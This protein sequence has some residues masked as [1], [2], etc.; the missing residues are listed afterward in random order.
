MHTDGDDEKNE[1][2]TREPLPSP[3][4]ILCGQIR[5]ELLNRQPERA[6]D[7]ILNAAPE[8]YEAEPPTR[9]TVP[10]VTA[11]EIRE[12]IKAHRFAKNREIAVTL[13]CHY[14]TVVLQRR[15]MQKQTEKSGAQPGAR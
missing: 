7:L 1:D 12:Y 11:A 13:G 14:K 10:A 2:G 3:L 15:L 8:C 9:R 5:R 4:D 6:I